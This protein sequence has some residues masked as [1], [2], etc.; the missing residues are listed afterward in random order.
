MV[1]LSIS[2]TLFLAL[3]LHR[4][5]QYHIWLL[6]LWLVFKLIANVFPIST[7]SSLDG[8]KNTDAYKWYITQL[9]TSGI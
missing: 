7:F 9:L 6:W 1:L 8:V 2:I 4:Y 5:T 3:I